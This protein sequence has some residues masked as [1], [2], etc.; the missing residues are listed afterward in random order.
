MGDFVLISDQT[1]SEN[2]EFLNKSILWFMNYS[3]SDYI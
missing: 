3:W 1:E 2:D